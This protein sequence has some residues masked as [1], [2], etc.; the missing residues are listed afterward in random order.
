MPGTKGKIRYS[1][2]PIQY[3]KSE[4]NY[5]KGAYLVDVKAGEEA[6]ISQIMFRNYKPIEVWKCD[7]VEEA[8]EKCKDRERKKYMGIP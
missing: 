8:L 2:S 6:E 3:S 5:S 1:G 4:I 7:S